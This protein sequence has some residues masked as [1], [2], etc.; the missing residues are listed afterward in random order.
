M[1]VRCIFA[2]PGGL[3]IELAL[4]AVGVQAEAARRQSFGEHVP[5][6]PPTS[7]TVDAWHGGSEP[8]LVVEVDGRRATAYPF[9]QTSGGGED[10]FDS[11]LRAAIPEL[12]A[13]GLITLTVSWPQAGLAEGSVTL[14]LGSLHDLENRVVWLLP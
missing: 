7:E 1:A 11:E 6:T 3:E 4:H 5:Q 13:D 12:P 2:R 8:V 14:T 10:Q 9:E